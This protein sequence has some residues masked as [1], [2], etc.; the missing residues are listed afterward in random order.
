MKLMKYLVLIASV[1]ILSQC[2]NKISTN[3]PTG[4][5]DCTCIQTFQPVCGEDGVE[6]DN[7]CLAE[8]AGI[9]YVEGTCP[10][11]TKAKVV[12]LGDPTI[13]GCGWIISV[14]ID[15]VAVNFRPDNLPTAFQKDGLVVAIAYR[16]TED[17]SPCGRGL[18]IPIIELISIEES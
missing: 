13:D 3:T 2:T 18:Q 17:L 11:S 8:C 14:D 15:G 16:E 5:E 4:L 12:D 7:S 6:Y 1:V 9:S 10:I